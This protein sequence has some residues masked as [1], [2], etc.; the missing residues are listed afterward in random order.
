MCENMTREKS[1]QKIF[2]Q[3]AYG[4]VFFSQ[5]RDDACLPQI[6]RKE[7]SMPYACD[8]SFDDKLK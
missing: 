2:A 3:G 8:H 5:R 6:K 7:T 4:Y 1:A